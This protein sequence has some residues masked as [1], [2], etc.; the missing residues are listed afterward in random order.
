MY[1]LRKTRGMQIEDTDIGEGG[2]VPVQDGIDEH[3]A[4][5]VGAVGDALHGAEVVQVPEVGA[6]AVRLRLREDREGG[7]AGGG[8]GGMLND[9]ITRRGGGRSV[10]VLTWSYL[11]SVIMLYFGG[12]GN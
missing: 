9:P 7:T 3:S 6:R 12:G 5:A 2:G 1:V 4:V 8:G 11:G 10:K